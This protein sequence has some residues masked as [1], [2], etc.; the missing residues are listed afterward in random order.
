MSSAAAPAVFTMSPLDWL[1]I[2]KRV[3]DPV[4]NALRCLNI[5]V[6]SG[7][8]GTHLDGQQVIKMVYDKDQNRLRI[9]RPP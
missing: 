8:S 6:P 1:Q 9:V 7:Q 3:Y 2:I 5:G 4:N